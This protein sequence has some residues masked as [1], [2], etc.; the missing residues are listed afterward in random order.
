MRIFPT[1]P[2]QGICF[3]GSGNSLQR[4]R[5]RAALIR[6][7]FNCRLRSPCVRELR[8]RKVT[9]VGHLE[10]SRC[11]CLKTRAKRPSGSPV[12]KGWRS[13]AS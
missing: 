1:L 2:Q 10:A 12:A 7:P 4:N 5:E 9:V 6:E 8:E 13:A 11:S 3:C